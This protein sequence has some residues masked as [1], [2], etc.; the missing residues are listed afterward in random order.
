L[1]Q[2]DAQD[3]GGVAS[4]DVE[5]GPGRGHLHCSVLWLRG[6]CGSHHGATSVGGLSSHSRSCP[7]AS[8]AESAG[9]PTPAA[10]TRCEAVPFPCACSSSIHERRSG[11]EVSSALRTSGSQTSG[12]GFREPVKSSPASSTLASSGNQAGTGMGGTTTG[13][14]GGAANRRA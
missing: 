2:E 6:A 9:P 7:A 13:P 8:Q 10:T 12:G 3:R 11:S 4:G 14:A 5:V 1:G